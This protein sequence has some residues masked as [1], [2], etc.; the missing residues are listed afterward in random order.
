MEFAEPLV[1]FRRAVS[2][3]FF[4]ARVSLAEK[5]FVS[6]NRPLR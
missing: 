3:G 4:T 5:A 2:M 1:G 6:N